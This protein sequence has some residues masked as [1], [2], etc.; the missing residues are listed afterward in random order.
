[1]CFIAAPCS[2]HL[3]SEL[4]LSQHQGRVLHLSHDIWVVWPV[5]PEPHLL[6]RP[7]K[8]PLESHAFPQME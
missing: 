1:M 4:R 7:L 8:V 3:K 5:L 2:P 6:W